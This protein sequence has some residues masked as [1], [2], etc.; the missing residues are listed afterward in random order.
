MHVP[1]PISRQS[2]KR[3]KWNKRIMLIVVMRMIMIT[4]NCYRELLIRKDRHTILV[5]ISVRNC[6][7]RKILPA[8]IGNQTLT[9]RMGFFSSNSDFKTPL[10]KKNSN[11]LRAKCPRMR[12]VY[13]RKILVLNNLC[14]CMRIW[15]LYQEPL[16]LFHQKNAI[17]TI[18]I[19][20]QG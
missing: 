12:R 16:E 7:F 6:H 4:T 10:T 19:C 13:D 18:S 2:I 15:L 8:F 5:K 11:P 14:V 20:F 17:H 9:A 3:Q 1:L